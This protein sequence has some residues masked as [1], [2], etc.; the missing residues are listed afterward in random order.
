M[1]KA[2]FS[3]QILSECVVAAWAKNG[4]KVWP[5]AGKV[6]DRT[7]ITNLTDLTQENEGGFPA[8]S[9]DCMVLDQSVN[10]TWKN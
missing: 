8:N 1:Y 2:N 7:T 6:K 3:N 5:G 4:I 10:H 9:P